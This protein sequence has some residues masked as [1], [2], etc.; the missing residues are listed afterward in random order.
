M[1][2][3]IMNFANRYAPN[4][5]EVVDET[6]FRY[7]EAVGIYDAYMPFTS[8]DDPE[9]AWAKH[10]H[11]RPIAHII[12]DMDTLPSLGTDNQLAILEQPTITLGAAYYWKGKDYELMRKLEMSLANANINNPQ[13]YLD[14][15]FGKA[16]YLTEAVM[17]AM[18]KFGLLVLQ[19]GFVNYTDAKTSQKIDLRY[20]A[21]DDATAFPADLAGANQ[22][23]NPGTANGVRDLDALGEAF[24]DRLGRYPDAWT[25]TERTYEALIAQ[26]AVKKSVLELRGLRQTTDTVV[27]DMEIQ[28]NEIQAVL[29]RRARRSAANIEIVVN[30][31]QHDIEQAD[32]SFVTEKYLIDGRVTA[33]TSGMAERA[34]VGI[35]ETDFIARI[36]LE[37]EE[38]SKLPKRVKTGAMGGGI[39]IVFDDR[40][41]SAQQMMP[42]A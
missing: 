36:A 4:L 5:R 25:M 40:Y 9:I 7:A 18:T 26:D 15:F 22:W 12:G 13:Q 32:G 27:S 8:Y 17:S 42:A 34:I 31:S 30:D 37:T 29:S 39:P 2:D 14:M 10:S 28:P 11:R 6:Y 33:L 41:L 23:Q 1:S 38:T 19:Q 21:A 3:P 24:Y 16:E 35:P 20:G